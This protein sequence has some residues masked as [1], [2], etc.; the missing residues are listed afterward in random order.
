MQI[1]T[2]LETVERMLLIRTQPLSPP[3]NQVS[4]DAHAKLYNIL[5]VWSR[6]ENEKAISTNRRIKRQVHLCG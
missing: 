1:Q 2:N 4:P 3:A 6:K 5:F